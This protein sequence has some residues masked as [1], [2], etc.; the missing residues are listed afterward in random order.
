MD[1]LSSITSITVCKTPHGKKHKKNKKNANWE[2][3]IQESLI[4]NQIQIDYWLS[5]SQCHNIQRHRINSKLRDATEMTSRCQ[6]VTAERRSDTLGKPEYH[7]TPQRSKDSLRYPQPSYTE[8]SSSCLW[9]VA[10]QNQV[11]QDDSGQLAL[12]T[13]TCVGTYPCL[14]L[15]R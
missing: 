10:L 12:D 2:C 11:Y 13:G 3:A 15:H 1:R 6:T 4:L 5:T 14:A 8:P 9:Q 7:E